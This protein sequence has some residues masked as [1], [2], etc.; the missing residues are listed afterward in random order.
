M[1]FNPDSDTHHT[2]W[3]NTSTSNHKPTFFSDSEVVWMHLVVLL[4][5]FFSFP[6]P[7]RTVLLMESNG[8]IGMESRIVKLQNPSRLA[9]SIVWCRAMRCTWSIF[10]STGPPKLADSL[11]VSYSSR[12]TS[13]HHSW[14]AGNRIVQDSV[15]RSS[16][17]RFGNYWHLRRYELR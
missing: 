17:D 12:P 7:N 2:L 13:S 5:F 8:G 3:H 15:N 4:T 14:G 9:V 16:K 10:R 11:R 6:S 1:A